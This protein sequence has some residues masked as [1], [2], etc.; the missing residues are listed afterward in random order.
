MFIYIIEGVEVCV[1]V[2]DRYHIN[3]SLNIVAESPEM[4]L[5]LAN[6]TNNVII[7]AT[8]IKSCVS[9]ELVGNPDP[10]IYVFPNAGCC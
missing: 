4:A 2:S 1:D 10:A 9:Y 6:K 3:G 5:E 8:D 7:T